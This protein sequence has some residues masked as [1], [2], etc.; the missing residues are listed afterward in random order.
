M[1]SA[2]FW[3][4]IKIRLLL[5]IRQLT[6]LKTRLT[7]LHLKSPSILNGSKIAGELETA[8]NALDNY[9]NMYMVSISVS[10]LSSLI[11]CRPIAAICHDECRTPGIDVT[12]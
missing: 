6:K 1:L 2:S 7:E 12:V 5:I 10:S 9:L 4:L 8:E 11:R 3:V